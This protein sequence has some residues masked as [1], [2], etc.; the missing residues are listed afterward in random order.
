LV[1]ATSP[2]P[3]H[4]TVLYPFVGARRIDRRLIRALEEVLREVRAFDFAL[5]HL[6][7]FPG[8]LYAAPDP[9]A[10]F[11]SITE[12][13]VRRW[14]EHPP[15]GGAF[16]SIVPHLTIEEADV[17]EA[18]AASFAARLPVTAQAREVVLMAP[19]RGGAWSRRATIPLPVRERA[20]G[21]ATPPG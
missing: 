18:E 16:E 19:G 14:P 10:P 9:P 3:P 21:P 2:L 11:I 5:T 13:C 12:A 4:I 1:S 6:D 8:V 7:R 20:G 17:P 15:F